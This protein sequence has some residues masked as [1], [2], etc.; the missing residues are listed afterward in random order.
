MGQRVHELYSI[1]PNKAHQNAIICLA[2]KR[3]EV[4]FSGQLINPYQKP[5]FLMNWFIQHFFSPGE[6]VRQ[7]FSDLGST[8]VTITLGEWNCVVVDLSKL[9]FLHITQRME[10]LTP[11][12]DMTGEFQG[13]KASNRSFKICNPKLEFQ[14]AE[15]IQLLE[16]EEDEVEKDK[17]RH[18]KRIGNVHVLKWNPQK[19]QKEK[20]LRRKKKKRQ[21][22]RKEKDGRIRKKDEKEEEEKKI[23]K[24]EEQRKKEG[25][26]RKKE[27]EERKKAEDD[28]DRDEEEDKGEEKKQDHEETDGS[29]EEGGGED[30]KSKTSNEKHG[31]DED[32]KKKKKEEEKE[33]KAK[34]EGCSGD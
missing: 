13:G 6:W 8:L 18:R 27:E 32:V 22:G 9:Q 30:R 19:Y 11:D 26:Q 7:L 34:D 4:N 25:E 3:E 29:D 24:E 14:E 17:K 5:V 33:D 1:W 23:Q 16:K 2:M 10:L 20:E 15:T 21:G 28:K 12:F 31:E